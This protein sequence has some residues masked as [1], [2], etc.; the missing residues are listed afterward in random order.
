[1]TKKFS[2][3]NKITEESENGPGVMVLWD[4]YYQLW[5]YIRT[6]WGNLNNAHVWVTLLKF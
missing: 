1:M 3:I 5:L 2:H 6:T 4:I